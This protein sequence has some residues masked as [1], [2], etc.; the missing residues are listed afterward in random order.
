MQDAIDEGVFSLNHRSGEFVQ[1]VK[2]AVLGLRNRLDIP[3]NYQIYFISSATECWEIIAQSFITKTS[4]HFYNGAFGERWYD[5]TKLLHPASQKI[6][7]DLNEDIPLSTKAAESPEVICL[8]HCETSNGTILSMSQIK[9]IHSSYPDS[10]IA[11]DVTSSM[12]GAQVDFE[13]ADIWYASVQK[14]FGLPAGMGIMICSPRAQERGLSI[15]ESKHYNSFTNLHK[16]AEKYQTTHTP[17]TLNI[18]LMKRLMPSIPHISEISEVVENR[19]SRWYSFLET[20]QDINLLVNHQRHR[21]PT[22]VAIQAQLDILNNIKN[23]ARAQN[24]LL[25]RGYGKWLNQS[26]RIANFPAINNAEIQTLEKF[27]KKE[28]N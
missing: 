10:L 14:C 27:F 2:D 12:A 11:V 3:E 26:F 4:L 25:G 13:L 6:E 9:H 21:S 28:I 15:N 23:K 5:Y 7:F 8:T 1:I 22:V 17:N 19:A 24:I 16:N 20:F 18:Y